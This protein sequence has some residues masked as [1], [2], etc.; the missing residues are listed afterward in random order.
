V[1]RAPDIRMKL[2]FEDTKRPHLLDITS[3]LYDFE[4]SH[5]FS[6][7]LT[8]EE[9]SDYRFSRYFWFRKGRR[10]RSNHMLRAVRIE[11]LSPLTIELLIASV[12]VTSGAIWTLAQLIEKVANWRLNRRKLRLEIQKLERDE[13][14][15]REYSNKLKAKAEERGAAWILGS[16]IGRFE[17]NPLNLVDIEIV[18]EENVDKEE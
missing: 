18:P 7:L 16:L 12:A 13:E 15:Y 8:A 17:E 2:V 10:L 3:L 11:K 14:R 9:Y 4:L 1:T 5:D 6:L